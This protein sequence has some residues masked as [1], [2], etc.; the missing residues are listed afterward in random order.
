MI[1]K[2]LFPTTND[3]CPFCGHYPY[4]I[5]N[6]CEKCSYWFIF[7][8][9]PEFQYASIPNSKYTIHVCHNSDNMHCT[10]INSYRRKEDFMNLLQ[11]DFI[12]VDFKSDDITKKLDLLWFIDNK[13]Y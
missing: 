10:L 2:H 12:D 3:E 5:N 4:K 1:L 6:R 13:I 8:D 11:Q 9:G 7:L